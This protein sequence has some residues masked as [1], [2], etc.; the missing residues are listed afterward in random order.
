MHWWDQPHFEAAQSDAFDLLVDAAVE[1]VGRLRGLEER[2]VA[3]VA[4]SFGAQL[5]LAL[6]ARVPAKID[7]LS[8]VGGILDLRTALV[9]LGL[10]VANQNHDSSLAA[11]SQRALQSTD[12]G[13]LWDLID[14]LFRVKDLLD[15]Y[16]SPTAVVQRVA[17]NQLAATGVLL[18]VPTY[19]AVLND[20]ITRAPPPPVTWRGSANV[21]IGR[22][23]PYALPSDAE[24]WRGVLPQASVQFVETGHFTHLELP[25]SLWLPRA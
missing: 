9:R 5:A 22:D 25:P 7:Y 17:M 19:Q 11:V 14:R 21:W 18:H 8:M 1:Q 24:S 4:S 3:L 10:H 2:P 12:G 6:I 13:S 16:W 23:D 20:F 15:F